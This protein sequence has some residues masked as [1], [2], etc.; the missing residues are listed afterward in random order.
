MTQL[1]KE[2]PATDPLSIAEQKLIIDAAITENKDRPGG[3][4]GT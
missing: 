4:A 1:L 2:I 3:N